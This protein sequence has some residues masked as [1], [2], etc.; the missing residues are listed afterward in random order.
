MG[1]LTRM[2]GHHI[3]LAGVMIGRARRLPA[4][5]LD[6]PFEVPVA[7]DRQRLRSLLSAARPDGDVELRDRQPPCGWPAEEHE[8]L[9]VMR[10]RRRGAGALIWGHHQAG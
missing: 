8:D 10:G 2:V 5:E 6:K 7:E 1:L 4:A 9:D 3:W